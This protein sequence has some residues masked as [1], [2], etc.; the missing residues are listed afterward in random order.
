MKHAE[1]FAYLLWVDGTDIGPTNFTV[2]TIN[3]VWNTSFCTQ[4]HATRPIAAIYLLDCKHGQP[5]AIGTTT[6]TTAYINVLSATRDAP[7]YS[8]FVDAC[9]NSI[10]RVEVI[11]GTPKAQQPHIAVTTSEV[12][13][14]QCSYQFYSRPIA[15]DL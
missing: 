4:T 8:D 12:C 3:P 5:C 10:G 7:T 1:L 6:L 13:Y 15:R 2:G 14:G 9:G 11:V